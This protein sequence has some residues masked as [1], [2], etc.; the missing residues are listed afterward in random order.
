MVDMILENY[1]KALESTLR[2]QKETL[3]NWTMQWSPFGTPV[4]LSFR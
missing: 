2:L 4:C 1:S 3:R